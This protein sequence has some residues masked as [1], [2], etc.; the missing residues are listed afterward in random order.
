MLPDCADRLARAPALSLEADGAEADGARRYRV[1][2]DKAYHLLARREHSA[3]E[4]RRK[5]T[6]MRGSHD[7]DA[8]A[9]DE[10]V[11]AHV[12]EVQRMLDRLLAELIEVGA[13]SDF[14]FAEHLC[15]WRYQN[16]R[17]PIKLRHDLTQHGIAEALIEQT[18]AQYEAKW[19]ALAAQVRCRKFGAS[20]PSSYREWAKQARFLRQRGF[21]AEQIEPYA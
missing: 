1:L 3:W 21:A 13:Q 10:R 11:A 18:M 19:S 2:R 20:A 16:G 15:R 4:L 14:R 17:G 6:P 12:A 8:D 7:A 5:L 9:N